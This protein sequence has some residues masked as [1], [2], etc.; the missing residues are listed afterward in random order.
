MLDA[1]I[2]V[3]TQLLEVAEERYAALTAADVERLGALVGH[4]EPLLSRVRRLE[5]ARLQVIRPWAAALGCE[6]ER[7]TVSD[8]VPLLD[9]TA[10]STLEEARDKLVSVVEA[11]SVANERNA[12]FLEVCLRSVNASVQHLLQTVQLDPRYAQ[13]GGR[14]GQEAGPRLTDYRA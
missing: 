9:H 3:Y 4:E 14:T 11:V 8:L 12:Q 1:Q 7:A 6:P 5:A 2:A 10:A 13:T